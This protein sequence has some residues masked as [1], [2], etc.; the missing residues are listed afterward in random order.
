VPDVELR[1]AVVRAAARPPRC[2]KCSSRWSRRSQ[3]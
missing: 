1:G 2:E 3:S